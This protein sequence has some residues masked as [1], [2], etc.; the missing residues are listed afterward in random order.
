MALTD[1]QI[2]FTEVAGTA[3]ITL[4]VY[5]MSVGELDQVGRDINGFTY[6][7]D[8]AVAAYIQD[9]RIIVHR[10]AIERP[11]FYQL[12]LW[13]NQCT[14][15]NLVD[16]GNALPYASYNGRINMLAPDMFHIAKIG[17]G[18]YEITFKPDSAAGP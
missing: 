11:Q 14:Y 6:Q 16:L 10:G 8:V 12:S 2:T 17:T 5:I 15:L 13:K 1:S 7:R 9:V 4:D 18:P 3:S